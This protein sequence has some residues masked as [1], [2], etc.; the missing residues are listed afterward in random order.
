MKLELTML[1]K[2]TKYGLIMGRFQPFHLGHQAI[3][4]EVLLE[5]K[6][7]ILLV[8]STNKT[9]TDKNPLSFS[10]VKKCIKLVYPNDELFILG[11]EDNTD[12]IWMQN[13]YQSIKKVTD[14]KNVTFYYHNK[15]NDFYNFYYKG[16][17]FKNKKLNFIFEYDNLIKTK[18]LNFPKLENLNINCHATDIRNDIEGFK[19]FLDARICWFLKS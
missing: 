16:K 13:I 6:I 10:Q 4:N 7:P 5:G 2:F 9:G 15:E 19:H 3:V 11:I 17:T 8:G 12:D 1:K 18:E 14:L